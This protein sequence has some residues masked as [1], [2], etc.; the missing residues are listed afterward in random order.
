MIYIFEH[1][2]VEPTKCIQ[3]TDLLFFGGR[4]ASIIHLSTA[5][6]FDIWLNCL[7]FRARKENIKLWIQTRD[8]NKTVFISFKLYN[9]CWY[10]VCMKFWLPLTATTV[11]L[12]IYASGTKFLRFMLYWERFTFSVLKTENQ[13]M[14]AECVKKI[15]SSENHT[16]RTR[17]SNMRND[18]DR[19][20]TR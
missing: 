15:P 5:T 11:K 3:P 20:M 10:I 4:F 17:N 9:S 16:H 8:E 13:V 6:R 18:C 2:T 14:T 12:N 7:V 1:L 19:E